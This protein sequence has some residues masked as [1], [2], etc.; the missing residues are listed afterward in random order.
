MF[1]QPP[2]AQKKNTGWA[3][4]LDRRQ[5][6]NKVVHSRHTDQRPAVRVPRCL[7]RRR[8][9]V[10]QQGRVSHRQRRQKAWPW[11]RGA[12]ELSGR[13]RQVVDANSRE[14]RKGLPRKEKERRVQP[15][16][17]GRQEAV[18]TQGRRRQSPGRPIGH[19]QNG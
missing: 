3:Q 9:S 15:S 11:R 6:V 12:A 2:A 17:A 8:L 18:S 19:Y 13:K 16:A 4:G 5:V 1:G 14:C 7:S 10:A